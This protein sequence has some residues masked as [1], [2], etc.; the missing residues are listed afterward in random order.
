LSGAIVSE[1]DDTPISYSGSWLKK[2]HSEA[3]V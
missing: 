3:V 2:I 1:K